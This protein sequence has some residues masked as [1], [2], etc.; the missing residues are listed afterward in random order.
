[1]VPEPAP[2][3]GG[4]G[5]IS[6]P[7]LAH[8]HTGLTGTSLEHLQGLVAS[9]ALLADLS[10]ADLLLFAPLEHDPDAEPS[11]VILGQIRPTTSQTLYLEDQV[12]RV[13]S[14]AERPLVAR[15]CELG[16]IVD[17]EITVGKGERARVQCIPVRFKSDVLG[18]LTREAA[19]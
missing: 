18:V 11:F 9:W 10:F 14:S 1:R 15:A 16:E 5:V 6:L 4:P 3:R 8:A 12:G 13:I 19:P 2:G 17:G 7:A